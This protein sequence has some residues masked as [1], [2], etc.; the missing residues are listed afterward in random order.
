MNEKTFVDEKGRPNHIEFA[1]CFMHGG[2]WFG[3]SDPK[4]K[5][6]ANLIVHDDTITKPTE[7]EVNAKLKELQDDWDSK[8]A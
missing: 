1:L 3:F 4:N 5:V 2:Q 6:Y 8:N 7:A